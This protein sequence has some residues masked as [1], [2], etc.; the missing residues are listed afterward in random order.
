[1]KS[2]WATPTPFGSVSCLVAEVCLSNYNLNSFLIH[3]APYSKGYQWYLMHKEVLGSIWKIGR[4]PIKASEVLIGG[5]LRVNIIR[6]KWIEGFTGIMGLWDVKGHRAIFTNNTGHRVPTRT[7]NYGK[8]GKSR[9]KKDP[10]MEKL[11]NLKK[12][13]IIMEKTWDFVK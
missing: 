6:T 11:C 9:K 7:G 13:W 3:Q 2:N 10:C 8:P 4:Y 1:M 5:P 12:P